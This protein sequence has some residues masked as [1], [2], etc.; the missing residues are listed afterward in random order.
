MPGNVEA[1]VTAAL[2]AAIALTKLEQ[3]SQE[4]KLDAENTLNLTKKSETDD[5]KSSKGLGKGKE[6]G[7]LITPGRE[8]RSRSTS[9]EGDKSLQQ[10]KTAEQEEKYADLL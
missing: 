5:K 8:D 2:D 6:K 1:D 10:E 9:A 7:R 3:L 4:S